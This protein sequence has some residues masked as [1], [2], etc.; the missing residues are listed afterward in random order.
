MFQI[1]GPLISL[2]ILTGEQQ[3]RLGSQ[4]PYSVPRGV[5][6]CKDSKWVGISASSDTVAARV[7]DVL[8]FAGDEREYSVAAAILRKLNIQSINLLIIKYHKMQNYKW[9]DEIGKKL[10]KD[11]EI[12]IGLVQPF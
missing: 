5:Y 4:L 11:I 9:A 6:R 8:G 2:F 1:M 10:I 7:I 12:K 3:P